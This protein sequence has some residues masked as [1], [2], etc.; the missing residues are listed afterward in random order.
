M[1]RENDIESPREVNSQGEEMNSG[2]FIDA[3]NQ[4][5][6]Q[7]Q[8]NEKAMEKKNKEVKEIKLFIII[9]YG[10]LKH[11]DKIVDNFD[12]EPNFHFLFE[13]VLYSFEEKINE[14]IS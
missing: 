2:L 11:M 14:I 7:F 5:N 3:M 10:L 9:M 4:L 8:D 13:S 12:L 6:V 1:R